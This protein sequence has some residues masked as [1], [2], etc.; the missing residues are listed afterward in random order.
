MGKKVQSNATEETGVPGK[1]HIKCWLLYNYGVS[2]NR[3]DNN[4]RKDHPIHQHIKCNK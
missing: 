3:N 2:D 4:Y 1:Q